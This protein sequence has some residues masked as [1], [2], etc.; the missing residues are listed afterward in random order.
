MDSIVSRGKSVS[1]AIEIGLELMEMSK[2][3]VNI[4][5]IQQADKK[6]LGMKNKEAIVRLTRSSISNENSSLQE[7]EKATFQKMEEAIENLLDDE[8][9]PQVPTA[10]SNDS[11]LSNNEDPIPAREGQVWVNDGVLHVKDSAHHFPTVTIGHGVR[12]R[13]NNKLVEESTTI[14]SE[15]DKIDIE[16]EEKVSETKWKVSLTENKLR[17]I[18]EVEPGEKITHVLKDCEPA[19]HVKLITE[20]QKEI[21]NELTYADIIKELEAFHVKH[22][23]DQRGIVKA[24]ETTEKET[25]EIARGTKATEG[26]NGW[27]DIKV[28]MHPEKGLFEKADG[29]IDFREITSIPMVDKGKVL[30]VVCPPIPGRPGVTVTNEPLPAKQT[31]PIVLNLGRGVTSVD[32]IIVATESGRPVIEQRG[33]YVKAS[34]IPKL[35]HESDVNLSSGN[36]RFNGYVEIKGQVEENMEVEA[37]GDI[38]VAK[39]VYFAKLT[40]LKSIVVKGSIIGSEISSGKSNMLITELGH[41]LGQLHT[42]IKNMIS[43]IKQLSQSPVFKSSEFSRTGVQPLIHLLLEKKFKNFVPIAQ[44]YVDKC[45]KSE[46]YLEKNAWSKVASTINS[47]FLSLSKQITTTDRLNELVVEMEELLD[48]SSTPIEPESYLTL[49]SSLNSILYSSG[50][51]T[52]VGEGSMNSKIHSG[53]HLHIHGILRGGEVHGSRGVT[54]KETG[55]ESGTKTIITVPRDQSIVVGKAMED[56]VLKVGTA[57]Y[58]VYEETKDVYARLN[59]EGQIIIN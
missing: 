46:A 42:Q 36:I 33:M 17:A 51:I 48:Y 57:T 27:I 15:H 40:S 12:L 24:T 32:D 7:N 34:V 28:K 41:L 31:Y 39:S 25:I 16:C 4:E 45:K 59:D 29:S 23:F 19:E 38:F 18:I 54:V 30:A 50:D 10:P 3:E 2:S 52:I 53:G 55:S 22:G 14:V 35:V 58:V 26:K 43:V 20:E 37:E 21:T 1:E 44:S 47:I 5:I 6:W 8:D 56:T 49:D 11:I 9:P 13:K